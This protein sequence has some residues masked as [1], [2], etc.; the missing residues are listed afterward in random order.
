MRRTHTASADKPS[1][2]VL[3]LPKHHRAK[4][5]EAVAGQLPSAALPAAFDI[6]GACAYAAVN[7]TALYAAFT[8]GRLSPR[9]LGRRTLV[10]RADLDA[11]LAALPPA[12]IRHSNT[13]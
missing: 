5:S 8:D 6:R 3:P 7:R 10:M 13:K 1:P 4:P 2:T 9:K 11:M 12:S